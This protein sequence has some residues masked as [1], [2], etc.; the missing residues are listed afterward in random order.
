M[1]NS[2]IYN[3]Y[4]SNISSNSPTLFDGLKIASKEEL[5]YLIALLRQQTMKNIVS[6]K[7]NSTVTTG[8]KAINTVM[9]LFG[10]SQKT[11]IE[12]EQEQ[13]ENYQDI[14]AKIQEEIQ[15]LQNYPKEVL[16]DTLLQEIQKE[17]KNNTTDLLKLSNDMIE[18]AAKT[19]KAIDKEYSTNQKADAIYQKTLQSIKST[20]EKQSIQERDEMICQLDEILKSLS[21][22][23]QAVVKQ[24]LKTEHLTGEVLRNSILKS[25]IGI[26]SLIAVGGTFSSYIA[27]NTIIHAVFTTALSMTVPF[28]VYTGVAKGVSIITGP[29]GWC[30]LGGYSIYSLAKTSGK[31]TAAIMSVIVF[32]AITL[33]GK[34]FLVD[35]NGNPLWFTTDS[36]EYQD[37]KKSQYE[38]SILHDTLEDI[39]QES[40]AKNKKLH[41]L[42]K[43]LKA[44]LSN[45]N[46]TETKELKSK[47]D[48]IKKERETLEKKCDK[49][50]KKYTKL[51]QH[52]QELDKLNN[53]SIKDNNTTS[54]SSLK[55]H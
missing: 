2:P 11:N 23:K 53:F 30:A 54:S 55:F 15:E 29:I 52:I 39:R 1:I 4:N 25:G 40:K 35:E 8:K 26:G 13:K 10:K 44:A 21:A 41:E 7:F 6:D 18:C 46:D 31:L 3:N 37:Y 27:I 50:T 17:L 33:Y 22:E 28:A 51:Q 24:S 20:L 16:Y 43:N 12:I 48:S 9:S 45:T 32:I 5:A 42:E 34:S 47:L 38:A 49:L 19:D 14:N 36:F